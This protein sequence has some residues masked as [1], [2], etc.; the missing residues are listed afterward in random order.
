M[1]THQNHGGIVMK[2]FHPVVLVLAVCGLASG[3]AVAQRTMPGATMSDANIMALLN[4]IDKSEIEAAQLAEQKAQS[5]E[6]RGYATRLIDEHMRLL[7]QHHRLADDLKMQPDKP[8]LAAS[9]KDTHQETMD[10]LRKKSGHEFDRAYIDYQI[11]MHEQAVK[12]VERTE[13]SAENARMKVHLRKTRPDLQ[14]H[15]AQAQTLQRQLVAS[16]PPTP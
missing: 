16:Q 3:C 11:R 13:D 2:V 14:S 6:V 1:L 4:T 5:P 12:L 7:D 15:L 8:R 10:E 9:L